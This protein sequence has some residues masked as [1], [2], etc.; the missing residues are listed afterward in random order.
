MTPDLSGG[1]IVEVRV[2]PHLQHPGWRLCP[3]SSR[4][5]AV[6]RN[7]P[8][9]SGGRVI[10]SGEFPVGM[11]HPEGGGLVG[12]IVRLDLNPSALA[13]ARPQD[14]LACGIWTYKNATWTFYKNCFKSFFLNHRKAA[15]GKTSFVLLLTR[16]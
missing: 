12:G 3:L 16:T 1:V 6:C 13:A 9:R 10:S 11:S 14:K 2:P 7:V 8:L 4:P 5:V 15:S